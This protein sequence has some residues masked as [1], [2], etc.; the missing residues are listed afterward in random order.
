MDRPVITYYRQY[1]E[2]TYWR[3]ATGD[4]MGA[5]THVNGTVDWASGGYVQDF[6]GEDVHLE[7]WLKAISASPPVDLDAPDV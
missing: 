6:N 5:P 3:D 7:L 1:D 4:W 2:H